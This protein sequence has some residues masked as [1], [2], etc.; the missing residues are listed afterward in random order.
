[1]KEKKFLLDKIINFIQSASIEYVFLREASVIEDVV[2]MEGLSDKDIDI[3]I[4]NDRVNEFFNYLEDENFIRLLPGK[5]FVHLDSGLKI[6]VHHNVYLRMPFPGE[7]FFLK[8][9]QQINRY[10]H[11]NNTHQFLVNLLHPL[12]L[13]G[14]RGQRHYSEDKY[15]FLKFHCSLIKD[16]KVKDFICS[17]LGN[18]FY[19]KIKHLLFEDP[20]LI[21]KNYYYLKLISILQSKT[22]M[23]FIFQ[24]AY[25]KFSDFYRKRGMLISVMGVDGSGKT[26]LSENLKNFFNSYLHIKSSDIIY[27]GMLGPYI[28]PINQLSK[29]YRIILRKEFTKEDSVDLNKI[30][31]LS[32][33][34]SMKQKLVFCLIG[35]DLL[36][37]NIIIIWKIFFLKKILITDRSIFDQHTKFN[38]SFLLRFI[39]K[40]SFKPSYFLFLEGDTN[41]IFNRKR[42]YSPSELYKHQNLHINFLKNEFHKEL[43]IVNAQNSVDSVLADSLLKI[44]KKYNESY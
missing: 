8:N 1:M 30:N 3:Y 41:E 13:A 42:E 19:T 11:L 7:D 14:F 2:T 20:R 26:T 31:N 28:L 40:I 15:F 38:S 6:D 4:K 12:D 21:I 5:L 44:T 37:R 18:S 22:L 17:W 16:P 9:I 27:M 32:F 39:R 43:I 25:K 35:F 36:L 34:K 23:K 29:I 24:R 10:S 33:F